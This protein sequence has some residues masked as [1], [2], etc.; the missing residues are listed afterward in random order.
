MLEMQKPTVT[1]KEFSDD[2][3]YGKF[4]VEPLERGFGVT[5]GNGI[6]R[7]LLNSLQGVAVDSIKIEGVLHE[8]STIPGVKEDV[9]EIVLNLKGL[10]AKIGKADQAVAEI[11]AVGPC[12]VKAGDATVDEDV[13]ILNEDL[14]IATLGENAK[15]DMEIHLSTGRGYVSADKN[16]GDDNKPAVIGVLPMDSIYSPVLKVNYSVEDTRVGQITDYDKLT[17]EVWTNGVISA[18]EAVSS[19][20]RIFIKHIGLFLELGGEVLQ[21]DILERPVLSEEER[22]MNLTI[23]ELDFSVR[24]YNC[25]KRSEILTMRDLV[26]TSKSKIE[27]VRNLGKKSLDEVIDKLKSFNLSFAPDSQELPESEEDQIDTELEEGTEN[28]EESGFEQTSEPENGEAGLEEE[29]QLDQ[30]DNA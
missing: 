28:I 20:A 13:Q 8:F 3:K 9:T 22:I 21:D 12:E 14:H 30:D 7:I 25:L 17:M 15:L 18:S 11:H 26:N 6:R 1:V 2:G 23:D 27:K 4:V 24:T 29:N 5:L 10:C 16:K 19:A